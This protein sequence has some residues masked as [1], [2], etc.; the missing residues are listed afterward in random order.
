MLRVRPLL[1]VLAVLEPRALQ[2]LQQQVGSKSGATNPCFVQTLHSMCFGCS[3]KAVVMRFVWCQSRRTF[4]T[5][6]NGTL[7]VITL[8]VISSRVIT[9]RV[10]TLRVITLRVITLRVITLR[11]IALRVITLRVIALLVIAFVCPV[12][13]LLALL[14]LAV[15]SRCQ[16]RSMHCCGVSCVQLLA[17]CVV[18]RQRSLPSAA[19]QGRVTT[20]CARRGAAA[21]AAQHKP[22]EPLSFLCDLSTHCMVACFGGRI[23]C[24]G[25]WACVVGRCSI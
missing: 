6:I 23:E 17:S 3:W 22:G 15:L 10:I 21:A 1:Q 9:L 16:W 8:R 18:G 13:L 14:L 2:Q 19:R 12:T 4:L 7:R 11:V 5:D 20:T 25:L 24:W